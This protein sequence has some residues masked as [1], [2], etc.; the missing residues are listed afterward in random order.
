[1]S[2][3]TISFIA[4]PWAVI[5]ALYLGVRQLKKLTAFFMIMNEQ[6]GW[7]DGA[8]WKTRRFKAIPRDERPVLPGRPDLPKHSEKVMLHALIK[9]LI[10]LFVLTLFTFGVLIFPMIVVWG[11]AVFF[12]RRYLILWKAHKYSVLLFLGASF[13]AIILSAFTSPFIRT[14]LAAA[15]T[16]LARILV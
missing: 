11:F 13:A 15:G 5:L 4:G 7:R 2:W 9:Y 3:Q 16:S 14:L 10:C 1:M 8:D 12:T 6:P